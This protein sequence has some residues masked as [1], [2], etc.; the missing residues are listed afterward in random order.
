MI[1]KNVGNNLQQRGGGGG[2]PPMHGT[3]LRWSLWT[4]YGPRGNQLWR[5]MQVNAC[6]ADVYLHAKKKNSDTITRMGT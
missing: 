3:I 6:N 4:A 1:F 2:G 5:D